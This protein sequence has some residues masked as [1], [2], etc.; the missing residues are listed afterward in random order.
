M[1]ASAFVAKH[2]HLRAHDATTD[3]ITSFSG[4]L[5]G[6]WDNYLDQSQ[7]EDLLIITNL[8]TKEKPKEE[9]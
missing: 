6:W 1:Y 3:I 9:Q 5:R 8:A 7:R 4:S 2:M